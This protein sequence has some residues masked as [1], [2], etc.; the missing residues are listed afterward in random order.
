MTA[1]IIHENVAGMPGSAPSPSILFLD[2]FNI[3]GR[4]QFGS[5]LLF[6]L[7]GY[8]IVAAAVSVEFNSSVAAAAESKQRSV[9]LL[10]RNRNHSEHTAQR[11]L[12]W[13]VTS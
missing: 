3:R 9:Q 11:V 8:I 10:G 1:F 4:R 13:K 7:W 12:L 6:L 5:S 2:N